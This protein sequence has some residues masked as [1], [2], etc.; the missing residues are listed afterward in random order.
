MSAFTAGCVRSHASNWNGEPLRTGE[1]TLGNHLT[2]VGAR[3]KETMFTG[4]IRRHTGVTVED[5]MDT[6]PKVATQNRSFE[7]F[8]V[9][10]KNDV[11]ADK[12]FPSLQPA[13]APSKYVPT[14]M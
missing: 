1:P 12:T 13:G 2:E 4:S 3:L 7:G 8:R 6:I 10:P 11:D 5:E 14:K 9:E